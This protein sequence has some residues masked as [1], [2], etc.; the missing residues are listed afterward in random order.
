[1]LISIEPLA[2][3]ELDAFATVVQSAFVDGIGSIL[4]HGGAAA[5]PTTHANLAKDQRDYFRNDPSAR[6]IKAVDTSTGDIMAVAKWNFYLR[7]QTPEELDRSLHIP[8]PGAADYV[9]SKA[10]ILKHLIGGRREFM[11]S[12]PYIYL[13]ILATEPKYHRRGA[14][15]KLVEWAVKQADELGLETYLESSPEAKLLYERWGFKVVKEVK[16]DMNRFGRPD[17]KD[18]VDVNRVMIR[19]TKGKP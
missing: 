17:L 9:A 19:Q 11:G 16:F 1:M 4:L 6:Y 2:E 5:N 8:S 3:E 7:E 10:P 18:T 13:S 12:K 14:G 15:G